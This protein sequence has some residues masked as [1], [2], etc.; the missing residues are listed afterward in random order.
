MSVFF[1][2]VEFRISRDINPSPI[3]NF[4]NLNLEVYLLGAVGSLDGKG[5]IFVNYFFGR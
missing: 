2:L 5:F 3:Q 1:L 4:R